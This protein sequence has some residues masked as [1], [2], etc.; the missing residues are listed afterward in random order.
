MAYKHAL[1]LAPDYLPALEGAAEVEYKLGT[2]EAVPLLDKIIALHPEDKTSHAMRGVIAFR[3]GDCKA[4]IADFGAS[5]PLIDSQSSALE[6]YGACLVKLNQIKNAIPVFQHLS[7]LRPEDPKIRYKL[8]LLQSLAGNYAQVIE[9]LSPLVNAGQADADALELLAEA[10]ESA[11]ETP[12]AVELL[13]SAI[14]AHPDDPR[15]Y[16]E[17]AN[18]SL[19]HASYQVGVD[20]LNVGLERLPRDASLYLARGILHIQLGQYETSEADFIRAEKLDPRAAAASAARGLAALQE[21]KPVEAE[22]TVRDQIS[23]EP[24]NAFLRYLLAEAILRKG[25]APGSPEFQQAVEAARKAVEL[26]PAFALGRD[27]LG[28]LYL[29]EGKNRE[30]IEQSRLA[31]SY[32]PTDQTALYH[33]ILALKKDHQTAQIPGLMKQLTALRENA[34][35]KESDEHKYALIE[36]NARNQ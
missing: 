28:R 8:A 17:F 24:H 35:K 25:A 7:E 19:V 9:I 14:L 3:K 2:A 36:Q 16:L 20:M 13:R 31:F 1:Q 15:F 10:Y 21:N 11:G 5:E 33:L 6:E 27:V 22:A 26:Q 29:Q 4:A 30:A 34:R 12:K 18:I 32:D 23:K